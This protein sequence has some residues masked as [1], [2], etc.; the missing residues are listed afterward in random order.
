MAVTDKIT[1]WIYGHKSEHGLC[2]NAHMSLVRQEVHVM[3]LYG[4][5]TAKRIVSALTVMR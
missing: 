4:T 5:E 3:L 1:C 2:A